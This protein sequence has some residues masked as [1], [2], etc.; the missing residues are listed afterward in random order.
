MTGYMAH[1]QAH[2]EAW[3]KLMQYG[4]RGTDVAAW[5]ATLLACGYDLTDPAGRFLE[6]THNATMAFQKLRRLG[7][8]GKV[9]SE[10]K[11]NINTPPMPRAIPDETTDGHDLR[12]LY[13]FDDCVENIPFRQAQNFTRANRTVMKWAVIHSMEGAEA[14]TKAESVSRW[15]AGE[16]TR[17]PAPKSS[18]HYAIDCDSIVQMVHEHH[19]AWH[20]P[21]ANRYGIGLE[22]AGRARQSAAQWLDAFSR[23]MLM[24]SAWLMAAICLRWNI[25]IVFVGRNDVSAGKRGI[26]TH[27]EVTHAFRKSTHTDPGPNFPME[28]YLECVREAHAILSPGS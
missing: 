24:Q 14:A 8:D 6:S 9:G 22:H 16:N 3:R 1:R 19:V 27:A 11:S 4:N 26:T 12:G 7:V 23:P 15:F 28:W 25:P 10:C 18:A 20:A 2:P 5:Q 21:G 17:F 13:E